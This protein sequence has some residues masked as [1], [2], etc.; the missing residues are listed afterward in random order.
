[1][2]TDTYDPILGLILQATGNN[3]N[4]WGATQNASCTT[5]TAR[6][7]AG[8]ATHSNTGGTLDLSGTLPPAGLRQD[9]DMIQL[10]NGALTS[11]L[12]VIVPSVSKLWWFQNNTSGAF[13]LFVKTPGGTAPPNLVQ[14]PQGLGVLVMGDGAGNLL[15]A[16]DAE[17]GA[18]RLSGKTAI[19][20][21]ELGCNGASLLR[22]SFPNLFAKIG[23]TWGSVDSVHFTLP[24]FTDT[25]RFLRSSSGSLSVGTYQS[26]QA[27]PHTHTITGVPAVGSLATDSQG[28]HVHGVSDPGHVHTFQLI[29]NTGAQPFPAAGSS[30]GS[31]N[32]TTNSSVTGISINSA[33]AHTHNVTG[34]LT[35]GSL[36]TANPA[37]SET[38]PETAVVLIG[39]RY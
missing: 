33:G 39:I 23:T 11:D 1:M 32:A 14:I 7:I 36:G 21:G 28:A 31:G 20:A 18:F 30:T 26:N 3:N 29:G 13:N 37:G 38:R 34:S 4:T 12:T 8:V 5:P 15:R 16:D 25:A 24:N 17:I 19:G 6:A 22:A 35:A 10:F 9:I 27:G 2:A